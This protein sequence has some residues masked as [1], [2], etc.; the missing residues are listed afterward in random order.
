MRVKV[1]DTPDGPVYLQD[2]VEFGPG[3]HPPNE[4]L[5]WKMHDAEFGMDPEPPRRG[6]R[7]HCRDCGRLL[8][9]FNRWQIAIHSGP[10]GHY[11]IH[12]PICRICFERRVENRE[13]E[14]QI[15]L[16]KND[17]QIMKMIIKN[18]IVTT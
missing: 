15:G 2:G 5:Y 14:L 16:L 12:T 18:A 13:K 1:R 3:Q 10:P 9:G 4:H 8:H 17:I 11:F 7:I 6:I